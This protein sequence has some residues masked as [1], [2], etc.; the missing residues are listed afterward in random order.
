MTA[1][2]EGGSDVAHNLNAEDVQ[3]VRESRRV[4]VPEQ[5]LTWSAGLA[6]NRH[7]PNRRRPK[8]IAGAEFD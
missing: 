6:L 4:C 8:C 7:I 2:G 3:G 1:S 5:L